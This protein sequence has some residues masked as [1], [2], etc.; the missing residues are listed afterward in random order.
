MVSG[1]LSSE[2]LGQPDDARVS[3]EPNA[4]KRGRRNRGESYPV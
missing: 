3:G 4:V 2:R 1:S